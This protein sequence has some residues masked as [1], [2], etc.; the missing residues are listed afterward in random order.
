MRYPLR[1]VT[2]SVVL[3]GWLSTECSWIILG[4][5]AREAQAVM[6]KTKEGMD[7]GNI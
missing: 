2:S 3:Y 6:E 1:T 5:E 4:D 7:S